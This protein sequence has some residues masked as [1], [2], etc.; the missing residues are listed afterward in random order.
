[1]QAFNDSDRGQDQWK[2]HVDD[3]TPPAAKENWT[4]PF[5]TR[6]LLLS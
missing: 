6:Q 2:Q 4:P 3:P 5:Q 1:M